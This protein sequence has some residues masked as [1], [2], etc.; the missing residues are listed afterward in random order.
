M[1]S[2]L[3]IAHK[4]YLMGVLMLS[5]TILVGWISLSQMAKIGVEIIDITEEDIPLTNAL[6]R[7]TEHQLQQSILFERSILQGVLMSQKYPGAKEKFDH[8]AKDTEKLAKKVEHE[9]K[10]TELFVEAAI[11]HLHSQ[12]AIDEYKHVLASLISIENVYLKLEE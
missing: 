10:D 9:L 7:L 12:V 11:S 4:I 8:A 2:S 6:T 1:A 5:L 3:K